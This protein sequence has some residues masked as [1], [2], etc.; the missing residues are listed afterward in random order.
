MNI[1]F[2]DLSTKSTGYSISQDKKFITYGCITSASKDVIE[3]IIKMRDQVKQLIK[4]YEI[5][6][7]ILEEVRLDEINSHTFKILMWLQAAIIIAAYETYSKI[8]YEFLAASEWRAALHMKQGAGIKRQY[9]KMQDIKYVQ[10]KYQI[11]VNDDEADAIC[12]MDA[13]YVKADNEIN[14]E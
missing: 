6:K 10:N 7:I 5:D 3:R 13:Y 4:K 9:L 8:E 12:L 1:L 2:L 14:W 11:K